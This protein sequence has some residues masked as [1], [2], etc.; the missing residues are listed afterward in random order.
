MDQQ[1]RREAVVRKMEAAASVEVEA[2]RA[3]GDE[4]GL[5]LAQLRKSL[6]S[7]SM[8]LSAVARMSPD[9]YQR[10]RDD[11]MAR[12]EKFRAAQDFDKVEQA[13]IQLS[14]C[15]T[16]MSQRGEENE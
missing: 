14:M 11:L 2:A 8:M 4:R 9:R 5:V 13:E 7:P 10:F 16:V 12:I 15:D 1:T 6:A 3:S